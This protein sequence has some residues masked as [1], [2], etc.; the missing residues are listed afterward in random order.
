MVTVI[1][2]RHYVN[3][4]GKDVF[5]HWLTLLAD[6]RGPSEDSPRAALLSHRVHV[7]D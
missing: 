7:R 6:A 3:R 5:D 4:A 2:V 1:E